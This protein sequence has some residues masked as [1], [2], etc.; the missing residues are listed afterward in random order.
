MQASET[1]EE[2][3]EVGDNGRAHVDVS[4]GARTEVLL[5]PVS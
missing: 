4:V 2:F 1:P 3:I 5:T